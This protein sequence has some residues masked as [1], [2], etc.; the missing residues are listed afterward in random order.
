MP[1]EFAEKN[2]GGQ[3]VPYDWLKWLGEKVRQTVEKGGRLIVN[4]PPQHDVVPAQEPRAECDPGFV[5]GGVRT[6]MGETG[7]QRVPR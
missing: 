6:G 2:S 3:W 7:A 1:H 4:A 5:R